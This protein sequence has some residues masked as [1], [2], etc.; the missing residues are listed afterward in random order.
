MAASSPRCPGAGG[1]AAR[2]LLSV[3][4]YRPAGSLRRGPL[5]PGDSLIGTILG[6]AAVGFQGAQT[7]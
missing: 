5:R 6:P 4:S 1:V 7:L 3:L 2:A